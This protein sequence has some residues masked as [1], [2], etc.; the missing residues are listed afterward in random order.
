[1]SGADRFNA[2]AYFLATARWFNAWPDRAIEQFEDAGFTSIRLEQI[3][4][5]PVWHLRMR[6][7]AENLTS[8]QAGRM[9]RKIVEREGSVPRDAFFCFSPRRGVVEATFVL[10]V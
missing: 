3:E 1:M 7:P 4:P 6:P 5:H 10:D 9:I 8:R 2:R